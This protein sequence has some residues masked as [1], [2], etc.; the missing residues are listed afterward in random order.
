MF[1]IILLVLPVCLA[2]QSQAPAPIIT[3][4]A[5]HHDFAEISEDQKIAHR[6]TVTNKGNAPLNIKEVRTSCDCT[7]TA[8]GKMV[9]LPGESTFIEVRFNPDGLQ[10][11]IH[12]TLD[13]I[14]D[15]P[16]TPITKLSFN[17]DVI[18]EI[19][20]SGNTV[21]FTRINRDGAG[22]ASL[23]L[24]SGNGKPITVTKISAANAPYISCISQQDGNDVILNMGIKGRLIPM[25]KTSGMDVLNVHTKS[26]K[27]PVLQFNI[28]WDVQ[29]IIIAEPERVTWVVHVGKEYRTTI[30]LK[31]S[32]GKPFRVI[33]AKSTSP[34]IR[35][36][37]FSKASATEQK[38]EIMLSS[39][40]KAGGYQETLVLT[41]DDR[42]QQI[43]ELPIV[44]VL[45]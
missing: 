24:Q 14:S 1:P 38:I 4:D 40:A 17:A 19:M 7:D 42:K 43:V 25:N 28:Q 15:D 6:Y 8:I 32:E 3:F 13:V 23:R 9:L 18:R 2:L 36:A 39:K 20:P 21:I 22:M 31:H 10:G 12:R 33:K 5:V 16:V 34:L 45:Q 30:T 29:P 44:A 35:I 26:K 41:L 27:Y 11:K 37:G